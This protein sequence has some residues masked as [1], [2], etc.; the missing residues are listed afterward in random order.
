M[1]A[2]MRIS[3]LFALLPVVLAA[4]PSRVITLGDSTSETTNEVSAENTELISG[5]HPDLWVVSVRASSQLAPSTPVAVIDGDP[6]SAWSI[7]GKPSVP[8]WI[9]L[10]LNH[11]TDLNQLT[12]HWL[13]NLPYSY[14]IYEQTSFELRK[15]V[16]EGVS[17]GQDAEPE[18]ITLPATIRTHAV[19]IEFATAS[20]NPAQGIREVRLGELPFPAAYPPAAYKDDPIEVVTQPFYVEPERMLNWPSFNPKI[21]VADGG[22]ARRILPRADAFE[23]GHL[24]FTVP[25]TPKQ[26]NWITLKVWES[27][28]QSMTQRGDLVVLQTLE[29]DATEINRTFFPKLVTDEQLTASRAQSPAGRWTYIHFALPADLIGK[30]K[31]F[32]L[33]LLGVGNIRRDYPMRAASPPIYTITSSLAPAGE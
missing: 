4:A 29:G 15:L 30:R 21:P 14:K 17:R 24:D 31:T 26:T 8:N 1:P 11:A 28:P 13:G 25:V 5:K 22:T 12:I 27:R 23:G 19:R 20:G 9:E 10:E 3:F 33:R 6:A 16:H 2:A 18:V 32:R 7:S